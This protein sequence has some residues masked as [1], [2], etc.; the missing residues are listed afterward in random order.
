MQL[1]TTER[2]AI[3]QDHSAKYWRATLFCVL[4]LLC[5]AIVFLALKWPFTR[6]KIISDL[7][8]AVHG[9]VEI[10]TFHHT[11]FPPGCVAEDVR[12][13]SDQFVAPTSVVTVQRLIFRTSYGKLLGKQIELLEVQGASAIIPPSG[14]ASHDSSRKQTSKSNVAKAQIERF[15]VNR[16]SLQ[17][18]RSGGQAPLTFQIGQFVLLHSNG[19]SDLPF[20]LSLRNPDPPGDVTANGSIHWNREQPS[21]SAISGRYAF[22]HAQL[23][24]MSGIGGVLSST[25]KFQGPIDQIDIQGTVKVPDF[26]VKKAGHPMPL[27]VAFTAAVDTKKG[28]VEL[29]PA[30]AQLGQS[31]VDSSVDIGEAADHA[32]EK[33]DADLLVN[34]GRIQDFLYLLLQAPQPPMTG[35]FSFQGKAAIPPGRKPFQQKVQL[36]GDF[37]IGGGK[38]TNP[39]T[40]HNIEN[41][42]EKSEGDPKGPPESVVSDLRGHV[43]LKDGTFTFSSLSFKAPGGVARLHGTYNLLTK[44]VD[45]RGKIFTEAK[46][47]QETTGVK[48]F[49]LKIIGPFL[50][51][52]KHSGG[53]IIPV[54]IVGTYPHPKYQMDPI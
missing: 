27:T 53:A 18:E 54:H 41:L 11:F 50:K 15:E 45:L 49:L 32:G 7:E 42:S 20:T 43:E 52:N 29:K 8:G 4:A 38:F 5:A 46:L 2:S 44:Q 36:Q 51:K 47:S 40:Q 1:T 37:G 25:G 33:T 14:S 16:A 30:T 19:S 21:Q 6:G 13:H 26:E 31:I 9:Q 17:V 24:A 12:L 23:G 28:T 39:Q 48:S 34:S 3:P 22:N 10:G 35:V